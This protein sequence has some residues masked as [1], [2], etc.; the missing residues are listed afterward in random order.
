MLMWLSRVKINLD[1]AFFKVITCLP[2]SLIYSHLLLLILVFQN[3]STFPSVLRSRIPVV[4]ALHTLLPFSSEA[5]VWILH[6]G[7]L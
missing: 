3:V 1:I 6:L 2:I 5:S 4:S 7:F